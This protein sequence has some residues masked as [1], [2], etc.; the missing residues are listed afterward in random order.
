MGALSFRTEMFFEYGVAGQVA[1]GVVRVV[2]NNPGPF[3][4]KGTNTYIVGETDL[5]V[6]DP[7]PEDATH[8]NAIMTAIDGR[9]VSHILITHTHRDHIDGLE[10]LA[11]ATGAKICGFGR[12]GMPMD[13]RILSPSGRTYI[14]VDFAPDI[15]MGQG[16]TVSGPGWTLRAIHTPGHALDHL[17]FAL[18]GTGVLFSGDHVMGWNT[19]VVAPPEGNMGDYMSSLELLLARDDTVYFPGHGGRIENPKRTCKAYLIHRRMREQSILE[20]IRRGGASIDSIVMQIYEHLD[21]KLI[22]AAKM[23]VQAHVENLI[24]RGAVAP[25]DSTVAFSTPLTAV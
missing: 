11:A 25:P 22:T 3:T 5:A 14:D 9:V 17:C 6:I 8:F 13:E 15:R 1:P 12:R 21:P 16:D 19:T 24:S 10:A 7:G 4:F 2:A 18:E 20:A 23:S